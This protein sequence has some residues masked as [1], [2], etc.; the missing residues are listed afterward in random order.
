MVLEY[1]S[2]LNMRTKKFEQYNKII[3][4]N[5]NYSYYQIDLIIHVKERFNY[6]DNIINS[7]IITLVP[8]AGF[9]LS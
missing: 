4:L 3:I 8:C 9:R 1:D 5:L 2:H 6:I 7:I